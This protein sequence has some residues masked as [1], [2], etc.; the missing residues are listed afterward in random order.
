MTSFHR[1][2]QT[3]GAEKDK[4]QNKTTKQTNVFRTN[5]ALTEGTV[6]KIKPF[7]TQRRL[8]ADQLLISGQERAFDLR[9]RC[10]FMSADVTGRSSIIKTEIVLSPFCYEK[11]R[12]IKIKT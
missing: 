8:T 10:T 11:N 4:K 7:W 1:L 3:E 9:I 6:C 5:S 12:K 2:F